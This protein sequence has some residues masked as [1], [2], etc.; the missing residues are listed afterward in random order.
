MLEGQKCMPDI[1]KLI[2]VLSVRLKVTTSITLAEQMVEKMEWLAS[3]YELQRAN[4]R[5]RISVI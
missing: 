3:V 2:T 4:L 1:K 5:I